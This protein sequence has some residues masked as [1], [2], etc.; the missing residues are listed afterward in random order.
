MIPVYPRKNRRILCR[1]A[2]LLVAAALSSWVPLAASGQAPAAPAQ[3]PPAPPAHYTLEEYR[4]APGDELSINFPNNAEL[5]HSG[6]I[7]PD[8]RVSIPLLGNVMLAGD[9][10]T[11][12]ASIITNV[13]RDRG[14]AA[15]AVPDITIMRYGT[16]VYV[17]GQVKLPGAIQLASGM[18]VLQA[19]I[20]AGGMTDMARTG[21]VAIIR[22][23]SDNHAN[24]FYVSVKD[25]I[26]GSPNGAIATLEP[27]DVVFVPRSKITEVDMWIDEYIN[28]TIPFSRNF[29]YSYGNYP[30]TTVTK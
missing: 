24:V 17:G 16:T 5:N 23:T 13:L 11:Q 28:K 12:A 1:L 14:I 10:S 7:G 9:T 22:R 15:N 3:T 6:P 18:D 2:V 25:Y 27:R 19:I 29:S 26:K 21:Q 8:G 20:A 30:V 4:L